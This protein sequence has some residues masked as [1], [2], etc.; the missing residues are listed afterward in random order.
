MG[1]RVHWVF[2]PFLAAGLVIH[3]FAPLSLVPEWWMGLAIGLPLVAAAGIV[4]FA[5][6]GCEPYRRSLAMILGYVAV[7]ALVDSLWPIALA[8]PALALA[9]KWRAIAV[10]T[11]H[12]PPLT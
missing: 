12:R 4:A 2:P 8:I 5:C 7:S 1:D 9:V 6:D 3:A 10:Q 11:G